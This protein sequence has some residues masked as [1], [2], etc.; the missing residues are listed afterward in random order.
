[1]LDNKQA[2]IARLTG[3]DS[4]KK[5]YYTELKKTVEQLKKKTFN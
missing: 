4:S 2:M 5:T 3:V 1:M